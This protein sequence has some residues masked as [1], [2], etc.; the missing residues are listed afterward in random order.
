MNISP[1]STS[2][3]KLR[4]RDK[5]PSG[6]G[7]RNSLGSRQILNST[8]TAERAY[9]KNTDTDKSDVFIYLF[10]YLFIIIFLFLL[11]MGRKILYY[12]LGS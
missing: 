12:L 2:R 10:I 3:I 9:P 6:G 11:L 4:Q 7:L 5:D 1:K 8:Q